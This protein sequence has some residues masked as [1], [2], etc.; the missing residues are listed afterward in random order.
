LVLIDGDF[1]IRMANEA[2]RGLA[3]IR[4]GDADGR[5]LIDL[6]AALWDLDEPL[7]ARLERL[8]ASAE[9]NCRCGFEHRTAGGQPA[10]LEVKGFVWRCAEQTYLAITVQDIT[11]FKER[12]RVLKLEI[13]RLASEAVATARE[14]GFAQDEL[15]ALAA[16]LFTSQEEERRRVARDLHD[17]IGQ[18]L[19][20][21]EIDAQQIEPRIVSVPEQAR[22]ELERVRIE[23]G[24]LS[25]DV[26]RISH[27]LHPAVIEDLGLTPALRSLVEDFRGREDMIVTFRADDVPDRI[28]L[29]TATGLYRIAQEA[30]RNVAKHA[31][32]THVKVLLGSG[33]GGIRLQVIDAGKGFD[34]AASRSGLGLISM[35]ERARIL[36]GRLR[37][38]SQPGEGARLT[39]DAPLP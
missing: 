5:S 13:E 29:E 16:S 2:F 31:G 14:L 10:V 6:A 30:L 39:I 22:A 24:E 36:Q 23:I 27:A 17:D 8:R 15:R 21:L 34:V 33:P 4:E 12:E 37:I 20:L 7:R 18:K 32:K 19:A 3:G 26:R 38:E 9:A 25:E 35:Q 28:P 1:R 11:A